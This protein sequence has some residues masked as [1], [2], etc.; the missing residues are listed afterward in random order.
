[1]DE[2]AAGKIRKSIT[3]LVAILESG[4]KTLRWKLRAKLGERVRW[5][6]LPE[7]IG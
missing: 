6:E 1:V 2:N 4:R 3:A 7:E 5:Y